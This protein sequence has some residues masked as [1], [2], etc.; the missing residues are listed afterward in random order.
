L[1]GIPNSAAATGMKLH[2]FREL[3]LC[4]SI[5][6]SAALHGENACD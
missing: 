5:I 4:V 6:E 2:R 3:W 1:M